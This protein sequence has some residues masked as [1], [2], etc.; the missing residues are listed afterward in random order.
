LIFI[1][2]ASR[3]ERGRF[4]AA[5]AEEQR[6]QRSTYTVASAAHRVRR[7]KY[8]DWFHAKKQG[9]KEHSETKIF[10]CVNAPPCSPRETA[11]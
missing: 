6:T 5:S 7:V 8:D 3:K 2:D 1:E 11:K 9:S 4:Y 10:C